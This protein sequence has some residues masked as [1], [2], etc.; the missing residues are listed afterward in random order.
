[1]SVFAVALVL[2]LLVPVMTMCLLAEEQK[3]GTL[4]L[5]LTAPVRDWDVVLGKYC[6]G[7]GPGERLRFDACL[8]VSQHSGDVFYLQ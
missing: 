8:S 4:E 3:L 5:L 7:K 2:I 6:G 1:M